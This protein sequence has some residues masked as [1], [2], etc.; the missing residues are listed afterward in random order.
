MAQNYLDEYLGLSPAPATGRAPRTQ[1]PVAQLPQ[2][3]AQESGGFNT[4]SDVAPSESGINSG[5][6]PAPAFTPTSQGWDRQSQSN[7]DASKAAGNPVYLPVSTPANSPTA[8]SSGNYEGDFWKIYGSV[9][10]SAKNL[11][12]Y[13]PQFQKLYPGA[14]LKR[15][16]QGWADAIVLPNGQIIDTQQNSGYEKSDKWQWNPVSGVSSQYGLDSY[17]QDPTARLFADAVGG[18]MDLLGSTLNKAY[19]DQLARQLQ[20]DA[21]NT[22]AID[23]YVGDLTKKKAQYEAPV[24]S[25]GQEQLLRSKATDPLNVRR[26]ATLK[27]QTENYLARTGFAPSSGTVTELQDKI[28][29]GFDQGQTQIESDLSANA[30]GEQQRRLELSQ[31]VSGL[32]AEAQRT[33]TG[34]RQNALTSL[35]AL[36]QGNNNETTARSREAVS[37]AQLLPE[38]VQSRLSSALS[39]LGSSGTSIDSLLSSIL[40]ANNSSQYGTQVASQNRRSTYQDLGKLLQL[41]F[42]NL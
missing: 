42:Q 29:K 20:E 6:A 37:T 5:A 9:A 14:Q 2:I 1:A 12:A 4:Q 36:E 16:A 3:A 11:E 40:G 19:Q 26:D 34:D 15:N 28:N 13:F 32:I 31:Y 33:K 35:A 18:H 25:Q 10:P 38:L 27:N 7:Y 21:A 22:S 24:Y 23:Q 17:F 30:I 8:S 39:T 41:V